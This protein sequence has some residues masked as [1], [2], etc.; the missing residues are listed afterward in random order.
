M[1]GIVSTAK[2]YTIVHQPLLLISLEE[3][4][5]VPRLMT[6]LRTS[7]PIH[8]R[9]IRCT[10]VEKRLIDCAHGETTSSPINHNLCR[11]N[12]GG[13]PRY[14]YGVVTCSKGKRQ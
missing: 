13:T 8:Y 2:F 14:M 10:G 6:T 9:Y 1:P 3:D 7:L 5:Q 12:I 4:V 11:R